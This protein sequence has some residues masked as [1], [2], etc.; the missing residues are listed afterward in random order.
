M[1][2]CTTKQSLWSEIDQIIKG[3][4]SEND[5]VVVTCAIMALL[6]YFENNKCND[7]LKGVTINNNTLTFIKDDGSSID[8]Q[9][10]VD[11]YVTNATMDGNNLIL[12]RNVGQDIVV[13]LS[14][15]IPWTS[16]RDGML[17]NVS[18][19]G[20]QL[21]FT[22]NEDAVLK[23]KT[24][25]LSGLI[26]Q[27]SYVD[28][29]NLQYNQTNNHYYLQL[30]YNDDK[31]P[32]SID[33]TALK[34]DIV[35][36]FPF[37]P[38]YYWSASK[39]VSGHLSTV[40]V[41]IGTDLATTVPYDFGQHRYI[42]YSNDGVT[43]QLISQ[44]REPPVDKYILFSSY[45]SG[46][47]YSNLVTVPSA[48]LFLAF[49]KDN[50]KEFLVH[51]LG[52]TDLTKNHE[53]ELISVNN[54]QLVF[55]NDSILSS[56]YNSNTTVKNLIDSMF[57]KTGISLSNFSSNNYKLKVHYCSLV[58][59]N[60]TYPDYNTYKL[61]EYTNTEQGVIDNPNGDSNVKEV[62]LQK[63]KLCNFINTQNRIELDNLTIPNM[64]LR[65]S[66]L[67]TVDKD[68]VEV[69]SNSYILNNIINNNGNYYLI[70]GFQV[71]DSNDTSIPFSNATSSDN[72]YMYIR[73]KSDYKPAKALTLFDFTRD[74]YSFSPQVKT[75]QFK[76]Y[77]KTYKEV[78]SGGQTQVLPENIVWTQVTNNEVTYSDI[79]PN[80]ASTFL[81]TD[82]ENWVT[83][84]TTATDMT[85]VTNT[86][87]INNLNF[88]WSVFIGY[89]MYSTHKS[90]NSST[91]P[92]N[93][94]YIDTLG[95]NN[96]YKIYSLDTSGVS[97]ADMSIYVS[98]QSYNT[99][100]NELESGCQ[101]TFDIISNTSRI[102][103]Y[104]TITL[105]SYNYLEQDDN[106]YNFCLGPNLYNQYS[107][108]DRVF[109]KVT[110]NRINAT[111]YKHTTPNVVYNIKQ[112]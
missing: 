102:S 111:G 63:S 83:D 72:C 93:A 106:I 100:T 56:Q 90:G 11:E 9:L 21:V 55:S 41:Y 18:L 68:I 29:G 6:K 27:D 49:M 19:N 110:V 82:P 101:I 103:G 17:T 45:T 95:W 38:G 105:G 60:T 88:I 112:S 12:H 84:T 43:Y 23:P 99:Q 10:P 13:D 5:R 109:P 2:N 75:D 73:Y 7:C 40:P 58:E 30:T 64:S 92:F 35:S 14:S 3:L 59:A 108:Y 54:G 85:T 80:G 24:I 20:T 47:A 91:I 31:Q 87:N 25:D 32:I 71:V 53:Q 4:Y 94:D 69:N 104:T 44:F 33:L 61:F 15:I 1:S 89:L 42:V 26:T 46:I 78:T 79:V 86:A 74:I 52:L 96:K 36:T 16:D 51:R 8:I 62:V 97:K 22:W 39:P 48:F 37:I 50:G 28:G 57:T 66:S 65:T 76:V 81:L 98:S 77:K 34:D 107:Q 70:Y 67:F